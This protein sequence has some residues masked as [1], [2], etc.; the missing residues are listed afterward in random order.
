MVNEEDKKIMVLS[1]SILYIKVD[2]KMLKIKRDFLIKIFK[3]FQVIPNM[4]FY[5]IIFFHLYHSIFSIFH[6]IVSIFYG[7]FYI[8]F[9]SI[10][11]FRNNPQNPHLFSIQ[12]LFHNKDKYT[13]KF[14]YSKQKMKNKR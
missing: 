2:L 11:G 4:T 12:L 6:S 8:P 9:H 7:I 13:L 5:F 10:P 14:E 1:S 3:F